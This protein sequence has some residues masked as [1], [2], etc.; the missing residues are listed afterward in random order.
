M[1][2]QELNHVPE[3][4]DSRRKAQLASTS[5]YE[6]SERGHKGDR[7]GFCLILQRSVRLQSHP[8]TA[9]SAA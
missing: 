4:A 7:I 6:I 9:K 2:W 8:F 1:Q 3:K 5:Y